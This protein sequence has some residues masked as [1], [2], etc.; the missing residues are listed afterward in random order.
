MPPKITST[1]SCATSLAALASATASVVA[2]SSRESS[3]FRPSRP[4]LA[5][6]SSTTILATLALARPMNE[7]PP[8][9]SAIMPTLMDGCVMADTSHELCAHHWRVSALR[10]AGRRRGAVERRRV[11]PAADRVPKASRPA[12]RLLHPGHVDDGAPAFNRGARC[13]RQSH[14][15]RALWQ[16]VPL[17]RLYL[18]RRGSAGSARRLPQGQQAMI[19]SNRYIGSP[20]ER[21]EDL[22]FL[23]GHGQF[24]GD[25]RRESMLHAAILRSP[26]AHGL[27]AAINPAA[28]LAIAGVRAVI[29]AKDVGGVPRIPLR[30]L[31]LPGTERFLQPV[32][33]A[34][35]VRY[36]GEPV[37][38][39]LADSP[40][41]A[42]DRS[43]YRRAAARPG[44]AR[45]RAR[46]HPVV[47]RSRH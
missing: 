47:R 46:R 17:H 42:E 43:R 34:D 26:V 37:A 40:A 15:F 35:R 7:S 33:A 16:F 24:V 36:A 21:I 25:L 2:P 10:G 20:V 29:T 38:V 31:P 45:F 14:P 30:L 27:I 23:R 12:M 8:V 4:P 28:A 22:R 1:L 5:L 3:S 19:R 9:S 32:I 13:G 41:L 11:E 6:I 18:D 39:V 44:S